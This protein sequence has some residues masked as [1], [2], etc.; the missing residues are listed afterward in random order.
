[1]VR[2]NYAIVFVSDMK[3]SVAFYRDVFGL[4]LK[5]ES[6]GW[7]EFATDGSTI[8]LHPAEKPASAPEGSETMAGT[9]RTGFSV[10]DL[11]AFHQRMIE[12]EVQCVQEPKAVF[13]ARIAQYRDLDGMILSVGEDAPGDQAG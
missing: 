5:F 12:H 13:G 3:S 1:M 4:P 10:P 6:P 7:S 8:A 9:C 2:V 11:D